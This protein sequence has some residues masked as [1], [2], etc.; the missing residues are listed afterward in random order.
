MKMLPFDKRRSSRRKKKSPPR[1]RNSTIREPSH[2]EKLLAAQRLRSTTPPKQKSRKASEFARIYGS[3]ERVTW[4][5]QQPCVVAKNGYVACYGIIHN[6]HVKNGGQGRKADARFI[7]PL[8]ERHHTGLH[9][10]GRQTFE[11]LT[12]VHLE[13]AAASTELAWQARVMAGES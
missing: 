6:H 1:Q 11:S 4:V 13:T 2:K 7:V 10:C 8:C 3:K 12:N 9:V 5:K